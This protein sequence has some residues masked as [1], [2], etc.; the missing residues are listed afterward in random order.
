[1]AMIFGV[2][3]DKPYTAIQVRD[4]LLACFIKAHE[5]AQKEQIKEIIKGMNEVGA[6]KLVQVNIEQNVYNAF[7]TTGGSFDAPTKASILK[8][9]DALK[10]F[11]KQFRSTEVIERNY[12]DMLT[13]VKGLPDA[14]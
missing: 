14:E 13:L 4:A 3:T 1:M 12:Q 8:A 9:M 5:P 7:R 2:Q 11:S 6:E 10:E